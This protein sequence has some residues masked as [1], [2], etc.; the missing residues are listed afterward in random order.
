[1]ENHN[2]DKGNEFFLPIKM[3]PK[4][5][6][7]LLATIIATALV[8]CDDSDSRLLEGGVEGEPDSGLSIVDTD[9][10]GI[11]DYLEP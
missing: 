11:P 1:M 3:A 4:A 6:K 9:G 2:F 10:D 8:G 7:L 5:K